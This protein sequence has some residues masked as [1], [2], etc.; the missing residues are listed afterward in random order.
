LSFGTSYWGWY[1]KDLEQVGRFFIV[2]FVWLTASQ[3]VKNMKKW[4][5]DLFSCFG[6][7]GLR[8]VE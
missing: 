5:K 8:K 3:S 2:I 6:E 4:L 1:G 7:W